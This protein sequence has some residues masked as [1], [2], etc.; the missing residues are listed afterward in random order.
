MKIPNF[1][2]HNDDGEQLQ[3]VS[4]MVE[5]WRGGHP[6]VLGVLRS[7]FF[8]LLAVFVL[9]DMGQYVPFVSEH[10]K[11]DGDKI[12]WGFRGQDLTSLLVLAYLFLG[13]VVSWR[14]PR[15][16]SAGAEPK[17]DE[18]PVKYKAL[19]ILHTLALPLSFVTFIFYMNALRKDSTYRWAECAMVTVAFLA[20]LSDWLLGSH[21]LL[22]EHGFWPVV[23]VFTYFVVLALVSLKWNVY[24]MIPWRTD[25]QM[26]FVNSFIVVATT[27][28]VYFA[29]S[30]LARCK[31]HRPYQLPAEQ[32]PN[33]QQPYQLPADQGTV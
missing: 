2:L 17:T 22:L 18:F 4:T 26:A 16:F 21:P 15:R 13:C 25:P 6:C 14:A 19:W 7:L 3:F 12:F 24:P 27:A 31:G 28:L 10:L 11:N 29:Q 23:V 32:Q 1:R 20:M 9:V 30:A 33:A 8:V 5:T